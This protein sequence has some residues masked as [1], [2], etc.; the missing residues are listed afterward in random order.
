MG[1]HT[2]LDNAVKPVRV[3][4]RDD[5]AGWSNDRLYRLL[6]EFA[7]AQLPVDLAVIPEAIDQA[8]A[9]GLLTRWQQDRSVIGLHQHG[10]NHSNHEPVGRK[11][12]FGS[13]RDKDQQ[14]ADIA[15]GQQ[16]IRSAFGQAFDP[17][18]TPPWNRCTQE[19]VE[20]LEALGFRLLSRDETAPP[21]ESTV[22]KQVCVNIDWNLMMRVS[23]NPLA[24]LGQAIAQALENNAL[25]GIMLHHADMGGESLKAL[26][27][28]LAV[29]ADH[30]N[31]QGLLL[32]ETVR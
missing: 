32:R 17:I 25:T 1:V 10:Y 26:A 2:V 30:D 29:F 3:F 23:P 4:F 9:Q 27:Q 14:Q 7:R 19:T 24:L 18:F 8:L 12:E 22:L 16:T 20:C 13:S 15:K 6:D 5:D 11:C 31:V 21:L 28:L